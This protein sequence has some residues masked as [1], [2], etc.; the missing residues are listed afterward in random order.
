[1]QYRF[2]LKEAD[3]L[4]LPSDVSSQ[5]A[6]FLCPFGVVILK[7]LTTLQRCVASILKMA[8]PSFRQ[9]DGFATSIPCEHVILKSTALCKA[10][11]GYPVP[12]S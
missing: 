11:K 7:F 9:T 6:L 4:I 1:M 12:I 8:S 5:H 10:P 2:Y 3:I